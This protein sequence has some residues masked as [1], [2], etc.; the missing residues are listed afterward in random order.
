[1]VDV[2]VY[3]PSP[4]GLVFIHEKPLGFIIYHIKHE[5]VYVSLKKTNVP[6][7]SEWFNT[8]L[9]SANKSINSRSDVLVAC[10]RIRYTSLSG[11]S[12]SNDR[13]KDLLK[14]SKLFDFISCSDISY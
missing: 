6:I 5:Q 2:I 10:L 1:M 13:I 7:F 11:Q 3:K 9:F 12:C 14:L 8:L 4:Y